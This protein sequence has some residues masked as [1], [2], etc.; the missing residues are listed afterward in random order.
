MDSKTP[1]T[2]RVQI[3]AELRLQLIAWARAAAP[4]EA[5]GLLLGRRRGERVEVEHVRLARNL[6]ADAHRAFEVHPEDHLA[7]SLEAERLGLDV[8]GAW[9]SHPRGPATLSPADLAAAAPG[10]AQLVVALA[11]SDTVMV[12]AWVVRDHE[13]HELELTERPTPSSRY[14]S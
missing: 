14:G 4:D 3:A 8:V 12:R 10:W 2:N 7:F 9:H 5:C 1:N 6:A 13:A 11:A